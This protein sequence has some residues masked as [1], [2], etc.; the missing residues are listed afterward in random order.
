MNIEPFTFVQFLDTGLKPE[1]FLYNNPHEI[2]L[3]TCIFF[4]VELDGVLRV[5]YYKV[6]PFDLDQEGY[7]GFQ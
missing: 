2:N 5:M 3:N 4:L 7:V 1:R 6:F